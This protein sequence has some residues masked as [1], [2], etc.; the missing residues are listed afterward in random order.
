MYYPVFAQMGKEISDIIEQL[1]NLGIGTL[2]GNGDGAMKKRRSVKDGMQSGKEPD[3]KEGES[4][5]N[6]AK[7]PK[8]PK[9]PTGAVQHL[10]TGVA[11]G[12][13]VPVSG[14]VQLVS[15][16]MLNRD[17]LDLPVVGKLGNEVPDPDFSHT[18]SCRLA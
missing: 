14:K 18:Q 3:P 8:A 10:L 9:V 11:K 6:L 1:R 5:A 2:V 17:H 4:W 15:H 13:T 12:T 16:V 7:V